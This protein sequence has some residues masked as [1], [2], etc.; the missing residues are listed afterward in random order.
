MPVTAPSCS[1]I[2]L[3]AMVVPWNTVSTVSRGIEYL[4]QSAIRPCTTPRGRSSGR[5]VHGSP[6]GLG[7]GK[8]QVH[9]GAAHVHADQPHRR[10]PRT[11]RVP[12]VLARGLLRLCDG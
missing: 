7:V 11:A 5:L 2:A 3:V 4:S 9:E 6:A 1:R 10:L 8:N 12:T